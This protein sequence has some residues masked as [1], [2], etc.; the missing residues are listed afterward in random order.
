M[1]GKDRIGEKNSR[2]PRFPLHNIAHVSHIGS[3]LAR[4][5]SG[6]HRNR[7]SIF[8]RLISARL[9]ALRFPSRQKSRPHFAT[10]RRM[11]PLHT[12]WQ[13]GGPLED[14]GLPQLGPHNSPFWER[15]LTLPRS[16]GEAEKKCRLMWRRFE[17]TSVHKHLHFQDGSHISYQARSSTGI[18]RVIVPFKMHQIR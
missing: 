6:L 8:S 17:T 4:K 10:N 12:E 18:L 16:G 11:P 7:I 3:R 15:G 9:T 2:L 13:K 1:S 5:V 14:M